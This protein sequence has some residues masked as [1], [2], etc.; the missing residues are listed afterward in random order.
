MPDNGEGSLLVY[1]V[2][3]LELAPVDPSNYGVF[4]AGD[5]YVIKYISDYASPKYIIYFW[6]VSEL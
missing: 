1:R 4:F 5:S 2:E 3:N 6:Q